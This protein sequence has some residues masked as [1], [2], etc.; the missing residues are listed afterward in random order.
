MRPVTPCMTIP[1][2]GWVIGY[3]LSK[4]IAEVT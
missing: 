4:A 3:L 1:S 2:L